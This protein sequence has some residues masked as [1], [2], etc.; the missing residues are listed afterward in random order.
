MPNRDGLQKSRCPRKRDQLPSLM[1]S[2]VRSLN[3]KMDEL[4]NRV[5]RLSP[6]VI[7]LT[8]TWLDNDT[9]DNSVSVSDFSIVRNDRNKF[10]GGVMF[11]IRVKFQI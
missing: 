9:P 11:Y 4:D 3:N 7:F 6:D 2:N 8:E 10:G 5:A 1:L